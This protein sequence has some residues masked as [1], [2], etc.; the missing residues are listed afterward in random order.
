V[1][2]RKRGRYV[3][4]VTLYVT[5]ADA[6]EEARAAEATAHALLDPVRKELRT[7]YGDQRGGTRTTS[8]RPGQCAPSRANQAGAP[9][10]QLK[11]R[12]KRRDRQI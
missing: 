1:I 10:L 8:W 4:S 2:S 11:A 7:L 5:T 9:M 12:V 6:F 3:V